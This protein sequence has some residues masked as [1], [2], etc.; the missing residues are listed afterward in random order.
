MN[1]AVL[2][3]G[4]ACLGYL[5]GSV[6]YGFLIPRVVSGRDVRSYG[7]G[8]PGAYNAALASGV[9]VGVLCS[10][11]DIAKAAIPVAAAFHLLHL[12][13]WALFLPAMAPLLGHLFPAGLHFR[14]GKAITAGF[15]VLIGLLPP[16]PL[17]VLWAGCLLALLPFLKGDHRRLILA[18]LLVFAPL[19]V[20]VAEGAAL[21]TLAAAMSLLIAMR[22]L[23][24]PISLR[25][26]IRGRPEG[27]RLP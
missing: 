12:S 19:G 21:K 23:E 24:T 26:G 25:R 27:K 16:C 7:D 18:S 20:I 1:A 5:S 15:G 6:M 9:P 4:M 13:S 11:L 22:H 17:A 14:G 8:N 10:V 2:S 3:V